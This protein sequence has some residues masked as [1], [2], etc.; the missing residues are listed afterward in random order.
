MNE[1]AIP[2]MMMTTTQSN[3]LMTQIRAERKHYKC[4][5]EPVFIN[6]HRDENRVGK[7]TYKKHL[8]QTTNLFLE[9]DPNKNRSRSYSYS[10]SPNKLK[11]KRTGYED[12]CAQRT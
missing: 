2:K 3:V 7:R 5:H 6:S 11:G 12:P 1:R 8:Y 4:R 9:P 10:P